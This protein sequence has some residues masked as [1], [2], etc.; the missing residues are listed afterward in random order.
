MSL[1]VV[2]SKLRDFAFDGLSLAVPTYFIVLAKNWSNFDFFHAYYLQ[3]SKVLPKI[4]V[5]LAAIVLALPPGLCCGMDNVPAKVSSPTASCCH[6]A[7]APS[8]DQCPA[9]AKPK[10][11]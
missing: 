11:N 6:R 9:P 4:V 2:R 1:I 5:L 7:T 8:P 10:A 3:M